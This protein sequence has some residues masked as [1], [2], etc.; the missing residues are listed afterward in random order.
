MV[1]IELKHMFE[2]SLLFLTYAVILSSMHVDGGNWTSWNISGE[3]SVT[4]GY[5][6]QTIQRRCIHDYRSMKKKVCVG[7]HV[8]SQYCFRGKCHNTRFISQT[9]V[10]ISTE[11]PATNKPITTTTLVNAETRTTVTTT[12]QTTKPGHKLTT[13][14]TSTV[15]TSR[16]NEPSLSGP[17]QTNEGNNV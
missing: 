7:D 10:S 3:C 9:D 13:Q 8:A 11:L 14:S 15:T 1:Q 5:G 16:T 4:C 6:S 2:T 17:G 12:L